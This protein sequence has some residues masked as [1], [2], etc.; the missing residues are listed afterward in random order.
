M[1]ARAVVRLELSGTLLAGVR[2]RGFVLS[3]QIHVGHLEAAG[4]FTAAERGGEFVSEILAGRSG[5]A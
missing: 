1:S 3:V 2:R 5:L 4:G